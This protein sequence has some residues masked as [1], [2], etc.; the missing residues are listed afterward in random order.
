M[1]QCIE[2]TLITTRN[3]NRKWKTCRCNKRQPPIIWTSFFFQLLFCPIVLLIPFP[4]EHFA[5]TWHASRLNLLVWKTIAHQRCLWVR[6]KWEAKWKQGQNT[7]LEWR[8]TARTMPANYSSQHSAEKKTANDLKRSICL[9]VI[10][11][12]EKSHIL[13]IKFLS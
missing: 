8:V 11:W 13:C 7:R 4:P 6:Y 12:N 3:Y 1:A 9:S 10:H 5:T 2:N